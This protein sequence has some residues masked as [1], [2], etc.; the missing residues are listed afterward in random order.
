M[1]R[2]V[3]EDAAHSKTLLTTNDLAV[4]IIAAQGLAE[5]VGT[6]MEV[7]DFRDGSLVREI[8]ADDCLSSNLSEAGVSFE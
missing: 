3:V 4:A 7:R 8:H 1:V 5:H 6:D 2:Y